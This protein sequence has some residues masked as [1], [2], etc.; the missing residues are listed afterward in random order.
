MKNT[1]ENVVLKENANR[2]TYEGRLSNFSFLKKTDRKVIDKKYAMSFADF[3]K[4]MLHK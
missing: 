3:K 2:Y 1:D 4:N